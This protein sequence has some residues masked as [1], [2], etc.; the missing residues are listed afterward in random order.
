MIEKVVYIVMW[1][2]NVLCIFFFYKG[3]FL[4]F[5]IVDIKVFNFLNI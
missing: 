5:F 2:E 1:K 4:M 3:V